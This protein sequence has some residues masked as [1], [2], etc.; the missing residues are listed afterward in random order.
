MHE[1]PERDP[2]LK[3]LRLYPEQLVRAV[4]PV[5]DAPGAVLER[6]AEEDAGHVRQHRAEQRLAVLQRLLREVTVRDVE[7]DAAASARA[8]GGVEERLAADVRPA[9]RAVGVAQADVDGVRLA[10]L[11]ACLGVP[12]HGTVLLE[13]QALDRDPVG[14]EEV[15]RRMAGE[16][17]DVLADEVEAHLTLLVLARHD[18]VERAWNV[19]TTL[20]KRCS[21]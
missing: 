21:L 3:R 11:R 2:V 17:D 5:D 15:A 12:E 9:N 4:R 10:V 19:W 20:R 18:G 16:R 6:R 1:R 14:A 13:Q 7:H 8:A